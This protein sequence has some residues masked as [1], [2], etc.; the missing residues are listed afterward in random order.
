MKGTEKPLQKNLSTIELRK[1]NSKRHF[2]KEK[3]PKN[4]AKKT[5]PNVVQQTFVCWARYLAI[6]VAVTDGSKMHLAKFVWM[7]YN[8]LH[9][10]VLK[11][12]FS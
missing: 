6:K 8:L 12:C 3:K 4:E 1:T 5:Q 7:A 10:T 9:D 2:N 11:E